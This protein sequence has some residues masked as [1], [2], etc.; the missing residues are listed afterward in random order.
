MDRDI[1]EILA[2]EEG[3]RSYPYQCSQGVTT[4]GYGFTFLTRE[5]ADAVL[6]IKVGKVREDI[7]SRVTFWQHL[8]P[9][10]QVVLVCMAF[11]LG[12]FGTLQFQ[13][14]FSALEVDDLKAARAAMLDSNWNKQTPS[15]CQRM[16]ERITVNQHYR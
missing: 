14:M 16:A 11:Q 12:T 4:I 10:T 8:T 3:F 13:D 5:E 2:V 1:V 7:S 9:E 6:A 15:R